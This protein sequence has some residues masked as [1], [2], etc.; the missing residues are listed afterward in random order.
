MGLKDHL[1][2]GTGHILKLGLDFDY[3][4]MNATDWQTGADNGPIIDSGSSDTGDMVAPC[5]RS[6]G[7]SPQDDSEK[8]ARPNSEPVQSHGH[9][10]VDTFSNRSIHAVR[11]LLCWPPCLD[12][13]SLVPNMVPQEPRPMDTLR[14]YQTKMEFALKL[15]YAED[16]VRL[17]LNKLGSDALINDILGELVKLGIKPENEGGT[18]SP[19]QSTSTSSSSGSSS[20][21]FSDS[22]DS[23]WSES[24]SQIPMDNKD[25]LRPIV[26]DGSNVAMR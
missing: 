2:D 14:E 9:S 17:V 16:L 20:C 6:C 13:D 11:P 7:S 19:Y 15:G 25:N 10:P 22:L 18:Q 3:L 26:I 23:R 5:T 21:S 4:H 1:D 24:P 12:L 8:S